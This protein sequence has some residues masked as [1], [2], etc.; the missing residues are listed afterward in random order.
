MLNNTPKY[1]VSSTLHRTAAVGQLDPCWPA[2][3][4]AVAALKASPGADLA[5]LGS[6]ELVAALTAHGL[7]DEYVLMIHPL[8]LGSGRR[9]FGDAV[10][11]GAAADRLGHHDQGRADRDV[12]AGRRCLSRRRC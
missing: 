10:A 5:I 4:A 1:V 2:T 9:L 3:R 7:V 8:V 11:G 6:G 12:R